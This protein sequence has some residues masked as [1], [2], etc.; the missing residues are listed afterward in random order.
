MAVTKATDDQS[1]AHQLLVELLAHQFAFPVR[2]ID[3]QDVLFSDPNNISRFVELGP[4]SILTTMA[5]RTHDIKYST[6]DM[7]V[8]VDRSFM[9]STRD[10]KK[11]HFQYDEPT[12]EVEVKTS[13]PEV[14][15]PDPTGSSGDH[16]E[17]NLALCVDTLDIP[18]AKI[19]PLERI[20]AVVAC[21]VK[22]GW[23]TVIPTRSIK[24]ITG[25]RSTLQNELIGDLL[26]E[27]GCTPD[28]AED[29]PLIALA[30]ALEASDGKSLG[31]ELT[32]SVKR[33]V[34]ATMPMGMNMQAIKE[35][36]LTSWGLPAMR[37]NSVLLYAMIESSAQAKVQYQSK[38][39]ATD[40]LD[41]AALDYAKACGL[42]LMKN[43]PGNSTT[44]LS[45]QLTIDPAVMEKASREQR[46]LARKQHNALGDFLGLST[47]EHVAHLSRLE[48]INRTHQDRLDA[49]SLELDADF[50]SGIKP[51][52]HAKHI[53]R[54][55]FWWNQARVDVMRIYHDASLGVSPSS[56]R[57]QQIANRCDR[58]TLDIARKMSG[59]SP[60]WQTRLDT[61]TKVTSLAASLELRSKETPVASFT[62]TSSKPQNSFNMD[63]STA[64]TE[65]PRYMSNSTHTYRDYLESGSPTM[66]KLTS[67]QVKREAEW[68]QDDVLTSQMLSSVSRALKAGLSFAG[69]RVLVTGAGPGSIAAEVV[70]NLLMGGAT[71]VVT[72]SRSIS[73]AQRFFRD[74]YAK[75]A[76]KGSEL[77][78]IPFNQ[79]SIADCRAL[80]D[81]IYD[82]IGNIDTVI[83]FAA[84]SERGYEVD[85]VGSKSEL[86]HRVMLLNV[87]RLLGLIVDRKR[88]P[89]I[90]LP[91]TQI[92]LP[93]SPNHGIFGGDGLYSES[94][95]G[96]EN[97]LNR[98]HNE[99]WK[100]TVTVCGVIIGWTRGT[101]LTAAN[102]IISEML[103]GHGVLTFS[104]HEM[105]LNVSVLV[106]SA[107]AESCEE[108]PIVADFGGG[109]GKLT[110]CKDLV[111]QHRNQIATESRTRRAVYDQDVKERPIKPTASSAA[112]QRQPS[113]PK[114]SLF[115]PRIDFPVRPNYD[116]T[117]APLTAIG[118]MVD[119][120][121]T[122]VIVGFSELGPWGSSRT[123]WQ[124]ESEGRLSPT[125]YIELAWMMGLIKHSS[126]SNQG[127]KH[128]GWIDAVTGSPVHDDEVESTYGEQI[129]AR[130]GIRMIESD[131]GSGVDPKQR[132][133]LQEI[134]LEEDLPEFEVG[135]STA[136]ALRM[137]HG[138]SVVLISPEDSDQVRIRL[139]AGA[140]IMV[141][142]TMPLV[143]SLVAG[144]LPRGWNALRYGISD[145]IVQQVDPITLFTLAC[146]SDAFYSSGICD[147]AEVFQYIHRS[148][149]GIFLG[150]CMGGTQKT[151]EMYQDV[152]LD[153]QVQS[154]ILQETYLNTPAAWINMLLLGGAGPIKTPVGAC[155]TGIE[156][157]DI[158]LESIASGKVKMCLVGGYDNFHG[159]ESA[160]FAKMKATVDT[161]TEFDAGRLPDEMSRPTAESRAGFVESQGAG[162]QIMCSAELALEMGL[163]IYGIVAASTMASDG[164]G[165][166][167][168]APG[169][170]ALTFAR[171]TPDAIN[172]P[173]LS[174]KHR[175]EQMEKAML[176]IFVQ[177]TGSSTSGSPSNPRTPETGLSDPQSV[178]DRLDE[179]TLITK[180]QAVRR[181]WGNDLRRL[182][183]A[184][185]PLRAGLAVWDLSVDDVS[186]VSMHGTSTK[187]NDLNEGRVITQQMNHLQR[188][189]PPLLAVCQK[190]VT[191]HPKAPA[192]SWM[193]NGCLQMLRSGL[194]PGN[195]KA[196]NIDPALEDCHH[197]VYPTESIQ[198]NGIKAFLLNS[199]G[200]GQKGGQMIG[201]APQYL[202]ATLPKD[203]YEQYSV[204]CMTRE[205][206]AQQAFAKAFVDG[207]LCN[208]QAAQ[209]TPPSILLSP[210]Q[211]LARNRLRMHDR[212]AGIDQQLLRAQLTRLF[213][214]CTPESTTE[215]SSSE[216]EDG[217]QS[218][219]SP[220]AWINQVIQSHPSSNAFRV[221]IDTEDVETFTSD[222]NATFVERNFTPREREHI[223]SAPNPHA[224]LVGRWCA[225]EAVF[226]S[227]G[228]KSKGAGASMRGIE[229]MSIDGAPKVE[230]RGDALQHATDSGIAEVL[231]SIT[232]GKQDVIA[233]ALSMRRNDQAQDV[234]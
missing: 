192:A 149:L 155:A 103:E 131:L 151:K 59:D 90:A 229:I 130:A 4:S 100:D 199:F 196:D 111:T 170:G 89:R 218:R 189:A 48:H 64:Y 233:I 195:T 168:P 93:L 28:G 14:S 96:L 220:K 181:Q 65:V 116:N 159:D 7:V 128:I 205:R 224:T 209:P 132:E 162:V 23:D 222:R 58:G 126:M 120:S 46:L 72:T 172:S 54:F 215:D 174:V 1:V 121:A 137:K 157:I 68:C 74:M 92:I 226:K 31:P 115:S 234:E 114:Q 102:D 147:P 51:R 80:V 206:V 190:S 27:F 221:G 176:D 143:S 57:L 232:Y 201:V 13:Q 101:G 19:S 217:L 135:L 82:T 185:S 47:Q 175:R 122:A 2:W 70:R 125:G 104:T 142:K 193:L 20:Q 145:D 81:Y 5:Q 231:V 66:P 37:Q 177:K 152:F 154:D 160:A 105:A 71:V 146:V 225:K 88:V 11:L 166:S 30:T 197:V 75:Y 203:L 67:C 179:R 113:P 123:R 161:V 228:V 38:Q 73:N 84:I 153:K 178:C 156:S 52:F 219:A 26:S 167:V 25:G 158:G 3:T 109:L 21:K 183:P 77:R 212:D 230:L 107:F 16:V 186:V 44:S 124:I 180:M 169:Q 95:L 198:T 165:R 171:E 94:K 61:R 194:V 34:A 223:N 85:S 24:E 36:L 10:Q 216:A 129:L 182:D 150:S 50:E 202:F 79:G 35:Y 227:L 191:G 78:L 60:K 173:M 139:L 208:L 99:S 97:L 86:A 119:L 43:V 211:P 12:D 55:N 8:G 91:P 213:G 49:W 98:W 112:L 110:R 140:R 18:D 187:A 53:R 127:G 133:L 141:P 106:T 76:G 207:T 9:A 62:F 200:F 214:T 63:G 134:V 42:S 210:T 144:L 69:R 39:A 22:K 41:H 163:P 188:Q 204:R 33:Y 164:F 32:T 40:A 45:A 136:E 56:D 15:A 29:M 184:I 108:E 117:I 138:Q 83:P 118:G 17:V 6:K 148:E 87:I